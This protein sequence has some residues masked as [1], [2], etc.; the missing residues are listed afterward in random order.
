MPSGEIGRKREISKYIFRSLQY[1]ELGE[2][3]WNEKGIRKAM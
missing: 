3:I 1:E 2:E